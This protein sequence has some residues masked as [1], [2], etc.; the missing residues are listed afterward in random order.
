MLGIPLF[1]EFERR[2][3]A[4]IAKTFLIF[5]AAGFLVGLFAGILWT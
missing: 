1:L 5:F 3:Q 4:Q 2:R